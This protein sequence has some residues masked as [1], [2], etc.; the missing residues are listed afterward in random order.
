M[1]NV[2]RSA[3]TVKS[4]QLAVVSA[5]GE[6]V[7]VVPALFQ[8]RAQRQRASLERRNRRFVVITGPSPVVCT[9]KGGE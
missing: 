2:A 4:P 3:R 9:L 7:S 5:S 1:P 8:T 6:A